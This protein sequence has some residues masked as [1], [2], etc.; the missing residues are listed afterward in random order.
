MGKYIST[1]ETAGD[2]EE[3]EGQTNSLILSGIVMHCHYES[4]TEFHCCEMAPWPLGESCCK[5]HRASCP[6]AHV[7]G[8]TRAGTALLGAGRGETGWNGGVN[9]AKLG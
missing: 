6:L 3:T 8:P 5:R 4:G 9:G 1:V 2:R 7:L